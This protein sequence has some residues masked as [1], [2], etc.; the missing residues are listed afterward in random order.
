MGGEPTTS[1]PI[2]SSTDDQSAAGFK[3]RLISHL[4]TQQEETKFREGR[5][6]R[7]FK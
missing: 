1:S 7:K 3:D 5:R 2:L 4:I 6:Q